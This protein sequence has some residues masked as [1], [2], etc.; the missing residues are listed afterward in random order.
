MTPILVAVLAASLLVFALAEAFFGWRERAPREHLATDA[1]YLASDF[2]LNFAV[3]GLRAAIP[4]GLAWAVGHAWRGPLWDRPI[5]VQLVLG[6]LVLEW[7]IWFAHWC[8][9]RFDVLYPFHAVHHGSSHVYFLS[10][11]RQHPV[12]FVGDQV[13]FALL[14]VLGG[15][16]PDAIV[17]LAIFQMVAAFFTHSNLDI[18][19]GPLKYVLTSPRFHVIHHTA[20]RETAMK[21]LGGGLS[22][23]DW[24]FG[25]ALDPDARPAPAELGPGEPYPTTYRGQL[26]QPFRALLGGGK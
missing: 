12:Q 1:A 21:N 8:W 25:T 17:L 23:F 19:F 22:L 15:V 2:G 26:V 20:S 13:F 10:G 16:R 5:W 24:L 18:R 9:H 11:L 3:N 4:A 7:A 14:L 6:G